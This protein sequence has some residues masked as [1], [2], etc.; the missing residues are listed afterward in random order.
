MLN[1]LK[2]YFLFE[3]WFTCV[4]AKMSSDE[5]EN[6]TIDYD[7]EDV[8]LG[9]NSDEI[10]DEEKGTEEVGLSPYMY[11]P[12]LYWN[13][14]IATMNLLYNRMIHRNR[15]PVVQQTTIQMKTSTW[16]LAIRIGVRVVNVEPWNQLR[17]VFVVGK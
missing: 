12:S 11:E 17:I 14:I 13:K 5:S 15:K 2:Y 6:E 1:V 4:L 9:E 10:R 7:Y 16:G 3:I 8:Y